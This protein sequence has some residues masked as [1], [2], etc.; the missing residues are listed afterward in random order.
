[1][2][3]D[4]LRHAISG[5]LQRATRGHTAR[6]I[7]SVRSV[8]GTRFFK[9]NQ[10]FA[11]FRRTCFSRLESLLAARRRT[12]VPPLSLSSLQE[13]GRTGDGSLPVLQHPLILLKRLQYLAN[14]QQA[15]A[16]TPD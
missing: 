12:R 14:F 7:R 3:L 15:D 13:G 8:A 1:M 4:S 16:A 9:T 6:E 5:F 2:H 10:V 11:H